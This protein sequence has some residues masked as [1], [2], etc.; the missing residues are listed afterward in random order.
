MAI[1]SPFFDPERLEGV[2]QLAGPFMPL[3]PGQSEIL[4]GVVSVNHGDI[5]RVVVQRPPHD[6]P[7][8]QRI[9]LRVLRIDEFFLHNQITFSFLNW[10]ISSGLYP[11]SDKHLFRVLAE[12]GRFLPGSRHRRFAEVEREFQHFNG[13]KTAMVFFQDDII[14]QYLHVIGQIG[15]GIDIFIQQGWRLTGLDMFYPLV[16][17]LDGKGLFQNLDQLLAVFRPGHFVR[18]PG[19][20][21]QG[22]KMKNA[23]Q[24]RPVARYDIQPS[25]VLT[26]VAIRSRFPGVASGLLRHQFI[27][28]II[29]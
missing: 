3:P 25:P 10:A 5:V 19:I 26:L 8:Q 18:K 9:M 11:Y 14:G 12:T 16:A 24:L 2:G 1:R 28:G 20:F 7:D 17:G 15:N 4:A 23:A 13:S 21:F 29:T 27:S 22:L 6:I